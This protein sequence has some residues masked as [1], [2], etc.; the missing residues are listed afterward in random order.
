[1]FL[2]VIKVK[3]IQGTYSALLVQ[4]NATIESERR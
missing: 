2:L 3:K 4:T 1:M